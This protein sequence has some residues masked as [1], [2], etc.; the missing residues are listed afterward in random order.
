MY[1]LDPHEDGIGHVGCF[2]LRQISGATEHLTWNP[3]L[4]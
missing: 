2:K 4:A 3:Q 1:L